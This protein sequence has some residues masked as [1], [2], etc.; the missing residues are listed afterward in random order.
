[1]VFNWLWKTI[2]SSRKKLKLKEEKSVKMSK[3][4]KLG[5][6][7]KKNKNG[8]TIVPNWHKQYQRLLQRLLLVVG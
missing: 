3:N 8:N 4:G 2:R 6:V 7:A 1:M 5:A